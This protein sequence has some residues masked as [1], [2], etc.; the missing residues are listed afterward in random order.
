MINMGSGVRGWG[1][2]ETSQRYL[3]HF[4]TQESRRDL[5]E[6]LQNRCP[7]WAPKDSLGFALRLPGSPVT[8]GPILAP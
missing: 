1:G 4:G 5:W 7:K 3:V 6:E 2:H 8:S